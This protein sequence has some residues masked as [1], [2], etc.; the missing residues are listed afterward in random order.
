MTP[1]DFTGGPS[2]IMGQEAR[3]RRLMPSRL[4]EAARAGD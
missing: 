3:A 4:D 1:L 2:P